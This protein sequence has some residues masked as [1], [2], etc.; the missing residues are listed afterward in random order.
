MFHN[1]KLDAREAWLRRLNIYWHKTVFP[2]FITR[3]GEIIEVDFG[4]N[5]GTEFSGRHL[6]VCL[7]ETTQ[8][9]D[10]VL[11]IPLTTKFEIYNLSNEDIIDTVSSSGKPIKAGVVIGEARWIS[12]HRIFRVSKILDDSEFTSSFIKGRIEVTKEQL[13]RWKS[14]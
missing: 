4:E 11:V 8:Y 14:L 6:A 5:V 7:S 13:K 1:T 3:I 2:R 9:S 10:R 12:K